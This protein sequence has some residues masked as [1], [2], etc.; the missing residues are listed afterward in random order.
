V[1]S[2]IQE[3]AEVFEGRDEERAAALVNKADGF[4]DEHDDEIKLAFNSAGLVSD[5][6]ARALYFRFLKRITAHVMNLL[7]ALVMPVDQLD[8]Y[9]EVKE[10]RRETD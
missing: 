2:L 9:D 8:Y 4:L 6:V 7:T 1:G 5:A 10:D 3:A